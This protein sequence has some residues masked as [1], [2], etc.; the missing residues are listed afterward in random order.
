M[1]SFGGLLFHG[2]PDF[3]LPRDVIKEVVQKILNLGIDVKLKTEIGVD[4][5]LE[6]LKQQY[7]A[8]LLSFG[9]N[10]SSKMNIEGEEL[11]RS[12]WWK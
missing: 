1:M 7:D 3:R 12:I 11:K 5:S 6:E 10:I 9:A 8:I 2:I 4:I